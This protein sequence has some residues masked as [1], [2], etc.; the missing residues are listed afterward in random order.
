MSVILPQSSIKPAMWSCDLGMVALNWAQIGLPV[1][2][3][4]LP[5][6]ERCGDKMSDCSGNQ[7]HGIV[8]GAV[9]RAGSLYFDETNAGDSVLLGKPKL[10]TVHGRSEFTIIAGVKWI[11]T[12]QT[13]EYTIYSNWDFPNGTFNFRIEPANNNLEFHVESAGGTT[14]G[15]FLDLV[16]TNDGSKLDIAAIVFTTTELS[17]WLNGIKSTTTYNPGGPV[18]NI[19]GTNN[20]YIGRTPHNATDWFN[21]SVAFVHR[22]NQ[23]LS[24]SQIITF[25]NNFNSI[26][27]PIRP[28]ALWSAPA[29]GVAPTSIFYGPLVGSLGGPI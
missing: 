11:E 3:L 23:T 9:W 25:T 14:G 17:A 13:D 20:I 16:P 2:V 29:V 1:P 26:V 18:K 6:L 5:G 7:H 4:S 12:A 19:P 22:F 10:L 15:N 27:E 8:S 28:P 21:G 24:P